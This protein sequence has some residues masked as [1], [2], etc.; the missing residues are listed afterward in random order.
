LALG[1]HFYYNFLSSEYSSF[2][3]GIS[4]Y[5]ITLDIV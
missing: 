2:A 5:T 4:L 3:L 1:V